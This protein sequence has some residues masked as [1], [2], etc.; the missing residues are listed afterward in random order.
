MFIGKCVNELIIQIVYTI[1]M[2]RKFAAFDIDGTIARN[3]LVFQIVDQLITDGKLPIEA[4]AK[5]DEKYT[6]YR[7]R[8]HDQAYKDYSNLA[9]DTLFKNMTNLKVKDYQ[10]AVDKVIA[11]SHKHVY[12]YTRDLISRLKTEGYFLIA[13]S[14]SEMYA[15]NQ[16][17]KQFD[18]DIVIGETYFEKDGYFT[19]EA[20]E[21][22]RNKDRFLK[23][24]IPENNLTIEGSLAVGDS[25]GD[26]SMLAHVQN[27]IAFNPEDSLYE[28]AKK[29][30]WK[31]VIERKNVIYELEPKNGSYL[32]A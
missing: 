6:T 16:F 12:V 22:Y 14:G 20:E 9:V 23:K 32:L 1:F 19:G 30:G 24:L 18:F 29:N 4:R 17:M 11:R 26:I 7:N 10:K 15:V 28:E 27:P 13:L 2:K 21:V 3:A 5:L 8:E 25:A 31:I